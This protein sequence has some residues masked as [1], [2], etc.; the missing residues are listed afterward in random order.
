MLIIP[1]NPMLF[2]LL[3]ESRHRFDKAAHSYDQ[4]LA[5]GVYNTFNI[6]YM[7]L[8]TLILRLK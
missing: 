3:Q 7:Q 2:L 8:Y 4:V 5:Y 6:L 1:T